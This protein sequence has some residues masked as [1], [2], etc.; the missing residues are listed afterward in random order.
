MR[1]LIAEY[2]AL[3]GAGPVG[4]AGGMP[5]WGPVAGGW[6]EPAAGEEIRSAIT[7][8]EPRRVSW[9]VTHERAWE[10]GLSCGGTIE[11]LVEPAVRS[12]ILAAARRESGSVVATGVGGPAPLGS[13]IVVGEQVA[14]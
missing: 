7:S 2:E 1:D 11:V 10:M 14:G 12:E 6:V 8:G 5:G 9:G 13:G 3:A 4:R